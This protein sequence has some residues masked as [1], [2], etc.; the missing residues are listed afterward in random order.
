MSPRQ[1]E[2]FRAIMLTGSVTGAADILYVSQ[3]AISRLIHDLEQE[4]GFE[5]FERRKNR[6]YPTTMAHTFYKEVERSFIGMKRIADV[7]KQIRNFET[8]RLR[9]N[10]MPGLSSSILPAIVAQFA[11][12]HPTV[13]IDFDVFPSTVILD[14]VVAAQCDIGFVGAE[15]ASSTVNVVA[16]ITSPCACIMPHGHELASLKEVTPSDLEGV[17]F[18][19]IGENS[20][21][22]RQVDAIFDESRVKRKLQLQASLSST[23]CDL[24]R[25]GSGVSIVDRFIAVNSHVEMRPFKP[26]IPFLYNILEP[27]LQ[28]NSGLVKQFLKTLEENTPDEIR[29]V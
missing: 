19:S 9:I 11:S 27:P 13:S 3:P 7:A 15:Q 14:H 10:C 25:Q 24:V 23:V 5:L 6:L 12:D 1:I 26:N 18:I 20:L 16:T 4:V 28:T 2:A 8:G 22:R 29:I 21:L 17:P